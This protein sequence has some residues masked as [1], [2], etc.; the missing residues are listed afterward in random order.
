MH[1]GGETT[2][3]SQ[4]AERLVNRFVELG[5]KF[6]FLAYPNRTHAISE[7]KGTSLHV[8]TEIARYLLEHL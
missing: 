5:K 8:H 6:D 2:G 7:G 1:G 3:P 4:G